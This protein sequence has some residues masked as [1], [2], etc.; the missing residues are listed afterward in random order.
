MVLV[1]GFLMNGDNSFPYLEKRLNAAGIETHTFTY[2]ARGRLGG[3][4][5][6]DNGANELA[7]FLDSRGLDQVNIVAHS[8]GAAV[9][10]AFMQTHPDRVGRV[11]TI[12]GVVADLPGGSSERTPP[13]ADVPYLNVASTW[14]VVVPA[15]SSLPTCPRCTHYLITRPVGHVGMLFDPR[16]AARIITFMQQT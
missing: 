9:T 4:G 3:F 15:T 8:K 2:G 10:N 13:L 16:V 5:S 14:D 6:F 11:A 7:R 1:H 12:G